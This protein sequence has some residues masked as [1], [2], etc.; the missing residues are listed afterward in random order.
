MKKILLKRFA[1]IIDFV[2]SRVNLIRG[3]IQNT[4]LIDDTF[5]FLSIGTYVERADFTARI[6]D[7]KYFILLPS[8][9]YVG[10]QIDNF[11]WTLMLR[12]VSAIEVLSR[13]MEIME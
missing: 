10:S 4:Q 5:D 13:H 2:K 8:S 6:I 11:Q 7:V 3:T 9:N 1:R 12:S